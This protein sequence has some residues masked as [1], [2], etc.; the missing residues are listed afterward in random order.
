MKYTLWALSYSFPQKLTTPVTL[1]DFPQ[2]AS[3]K[4]KPKFIR[5]CKLIQHAPCMYSSLF[6]GI[7]FPQIPQV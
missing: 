3:H 7:V 6:S 4:S 5:A 1:R 2:N